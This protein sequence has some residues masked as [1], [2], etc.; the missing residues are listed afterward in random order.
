M[1]IR[2]IISKQDPVGKTIKDLGYKFEEVDEDVTDFKYD[3]GDA[4]IVF[5]RHESKSKIPSYTVH[6]PGNPTSQTLGGEP[7]KLGM[8]YPRLLTSIYRELLK[9]PENALNKSLEATHHGPTYQRTPIIFVEIGSSIEY[10]S[11]QKLVK[12]LVEATLR[13]VEKFREIECNETVSG[14]GGPHYAPLFSKLAGK[15]SCVS[16]ILSKYVLSETNENVIAQ[17]ITNSIERINKV[18]F[19]NVNK[20]LKLKLLSTIRN[21]D[22]AIESV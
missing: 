15:S 6:Y 10:W 2:F 12:A 17:A 5:S 21:F 13:G 11:N 9:I 20:E 3:S 14:F 8:A 7:Y 19:D 18:I 1:D 22:V 4:I 16:H